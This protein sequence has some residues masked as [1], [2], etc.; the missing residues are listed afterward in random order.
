M[1]RARIRA[2]IAVALVLALCVVIFLFSARPAVVSAQDSGG[3]AEALAR[4]FN[5]QFDALAAAE[6]NA[7]L[8]FFDH[9]VRKTAHF[10]E[11]A[12]LGA[13]SANAALQLMAWKHAWHAAHYEGPSYPAGVTPDAANAAD[14]LRRIWAPA[15]FGWAFATCYAATDELHQ[16]F[17]PGRAGMLSD[18]VLDSCGALAGATLVALV[19]HARARRAKDQVDS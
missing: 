19:A 14:P 4:L 8:H 5:P 6:R 12:A 17:V 9:L 16:L 13:L 7:A 11:Y 2:Y 18:V 1:R 10:L 15:L 3:I